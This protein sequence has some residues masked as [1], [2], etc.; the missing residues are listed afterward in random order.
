[1]IK[2]GV[3]G[4]GEMG[5]NH[6]RV[7]SELKGVKLIGVADIDETKGME[8]S[9]K[10]SCKYFKDYKELLK[11]VDAVSVV[12]P[13]FL[14]KEVALDAANA[15]VNMLVEKPIADNIENAKKI[16]EACKKNRVK[17]MIGHIERF[18]PIIPAIKKNIKDKK[19][20]SIEITRVGP[21]PQR[22]KDVGVI[23]DIGVHDI[24]LVKYLTDSDFKEIHSLT[25]STNNTQHEDIG[26]LSFRMKNGALAQITTNWLT[27]FKVREI[28]ISTNENFLRGSFLDQTL[29][30]YSKY[31]EDGSYVTKQIPVKIEEPLKL[32]LESFI[33]S[34]NNNTEPK[35]SGKDGLKA[36]EIALKCCK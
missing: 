16:V 24:D 35:V 21:F 15:G 29:F 36:L 8:I 6:V 7:Y 25:T 26:I 9:K 28:E 23:V 17:L 20:F 4:I 13:T 30:E 3:I 22:V 31:K 34:L 14:H 11:E 33:E 12:V 1:M 18:N 27:P 2:I 32:E 19:V 5:K 10:Y